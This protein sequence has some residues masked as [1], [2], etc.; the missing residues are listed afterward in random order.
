ME[1]PTYRQISLN[2]HPGT[3]VTIILL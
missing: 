1:M 2:G 3:T